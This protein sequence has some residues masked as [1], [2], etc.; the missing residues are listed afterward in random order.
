[1]LPRFKEEF[2]QQRT[3]HLLDAGYCSGP[4][5]HAIDAVAHKFIRCSKPGYIPTLYTEALT[6]RTFYPRVRF[7][8]YRYL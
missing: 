3:A 6:L 5:F 8:F 4:L 2:P 1:M 7:S